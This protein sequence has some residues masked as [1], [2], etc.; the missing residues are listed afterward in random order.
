MAGF[1][2]AGLAE[3]TYPT[4]QHFTIYWRDITKL[5]AQALIFLHGHD[6]VGDLHRLSLPHPHRAGQLA[7]LQKHRGSPEAGLDFAIEQGWLW[8]HESGTYV[9]F[10]DAGSELL[11]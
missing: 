1:L 5:F 8:L 11:A 6:G 2:F 4:W 10:T 7:F 9:K 3:L